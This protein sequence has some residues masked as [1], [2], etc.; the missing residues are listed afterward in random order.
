SGH[1]EL[2]VD[3]LELV[4]AHD[5]R[6]LGEPALEELLEL[7]GGSEGCVVVEVDVRDYGDLRTQ[8]LD[9]AVGFIALD[10][11]P[12]GTGARVPVEVRNRPANEERWIVAEPV[13]AEG[14]HPGGGRLPVRAR[15]DERAAQR[16]ELREQVGP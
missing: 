13:E 4:A 5:L 12:A 3:R 6:H 1:R 14:D 15:D 16:D 7:G 10:D 2:E 9:R 11:K 8:A